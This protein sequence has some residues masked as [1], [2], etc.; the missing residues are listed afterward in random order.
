MANTVKNTPKNTAKGLVDATT[1]AIPTDAIPVAPITDNEDEDEAP[2]TDVSRIRQ[3]DEDRKAQA[4]KIAALEDAKFK[5]RDATVQGTALTMKVGVT[6]SELAFAMV[7]KMRGAIK[8][9][10][11]E[12]ADR[13]NQVLPSEQHIR[14][15]VTEMNK[16]NRLIGDTD[17]FA[18]EISLTYSIGGQK[19][20]VRGSELEPNE[21]VVFMEEYANILQRI[22]DARTIEN[23]LRHSRS[24]SGDFTAAQ[25]LLKTA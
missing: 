23:F 25:D 12:V 24:F 3:L 5:E 18:N 13:D 15:T 10:T 7:K 16:I 20:T 19:Y 11:V 8:D 1:G 22:G 14:T 9:L 2:R 6:R 21:M 4:K 17:P